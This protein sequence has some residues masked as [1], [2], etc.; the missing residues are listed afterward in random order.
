MRQDSPALEPPGLLREE[1]I[2]I[3]NKMISLFSI[4]YLSQQSGIHNIL[5]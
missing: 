2:E 1:D 5:S 4:H 3:I